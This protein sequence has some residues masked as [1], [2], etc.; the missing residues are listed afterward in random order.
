MVKSD[1]E[2]VELL[3]V[4]DEKAFEYIFDTYFYRLCLL[5]RGITKSQD[6]AEEIVEELFLQLWLNCQIN[7]V[8]TSIKSYLFK[9]VYNNSIKY[10]S[11]K[12]RFISLDSG[13]Y[14]PEPFV[15]EYPLSNMISGELEE[16]AREI[17][18][19]L[20]D[21]CKQIYQLN[22]DKNM[23]YHEIASLLNISVGTVKTQMSRAYAKLREGL[24]DFL[25]VFL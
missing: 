1:F 21:Q 13:E 3:K 24:K 23:K 10:N 18:L 6:S 9:S 22:R 15:Q 17:I 11:Q 20:P 12:K 4:G 14:F 16:K 5:A 8:Q 19:K 2:L 7:P 25:S